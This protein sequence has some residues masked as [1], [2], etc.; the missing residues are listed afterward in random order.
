MLGL[1]GCY[2]CKHAV[3]LALWVLLHDNHLYKVLYL[4]LSRHNYIYR[5][6]CLALAKFYGSKW[7]LVGLITVAHAIVL[8]LNGLHGNQNVVFMALGKLTLSGILVY[9]ALN[10]CYGYQHTVYFALC[11]FV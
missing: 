4:E 2:G 5:S 1:N 11:R 9:W 6:V 3:C 8:A 7:Y 10:G